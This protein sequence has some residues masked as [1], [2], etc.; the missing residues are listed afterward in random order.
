VL[1]SDKSF[2][3]LEEAGMMAT[4]LQWLEGKT[5]EDSFPAEIREGRDYGLQAQ[6][7]NMMLYD[8]EGNVEHV[9]YT[10]AEDGLVAY[11]WEERDENT[12]IEDRGELH[13]MPGSDTDIEYNGMGL[14]L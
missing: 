11:M 7:G 13:L 5:I 12:H 4:G 3:E 14:D 2:E 9:G 6:S 8:S 10:E 1:G